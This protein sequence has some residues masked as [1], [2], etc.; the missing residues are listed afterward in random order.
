MDS[1]SLI[2]VLILFAVSEATSKRMFCRHNGDCEYN[3]ICDPE[4]TTCYRKPES[5]GDFCLKN[6][7]CNQID[8]SSVCRGNV[9]QCA[10][11]RYSSKGICVPYMD[12]TVWLLIVMSVLLFLSMSCTI[13]YALPFVCDNHPQEVRED[14]TAPSNAHHLNDPPPKYESLNL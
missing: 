11:G 6:C 3:E 12:H 13:F 5:L 2:H 9:C 4:G 8:P 14:S 7:D 10:D 1:A